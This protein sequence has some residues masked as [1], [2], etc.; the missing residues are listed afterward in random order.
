MD[1][2]IVTETADTTFYDSP[3]TERPAG[4]GQPI[5]NPDLHE[6]ARAGTAVFGEAVAM[7]ADVL[8]VE[9]DEIVCEPSSPRP[10]R[11]S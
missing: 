8:G 10:P 1:K 6:M 9:L 4:F 3:D 11:T 2:V 7:V 5:G